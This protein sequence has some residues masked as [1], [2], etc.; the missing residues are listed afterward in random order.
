MSKKTFLI[1]LCLNFNAYGVDNI[2][3][4]ENTALFSAYYESL[5]IITSKYI[6]RDKNGKRSHGKFQTT[7]FLSENTY[8]KST[9]TGTFTNF[10]IELNGS[11]KVTD[12]QL[13]WTYIW[14]PKKAPSN[15]VSFGI[16]FN[17]QLDSP[18][19][20]S[21]A[22]TPELLPDNLGWRWVSPK[23]KHIEVNFSPALARITFEKDN[24]QKILA[25]FFSDMQKTLMTVKI[26]KDIA[27]KRPISLD[28]DNFSAHSWHKD[29]LPETTSPVD[30]SFLNLSDKPAGSHGY[31]VSRNESLFFEDGTPAK[32][33]G[34]NIM[35]RAIFKTSD[36]DIKRHARRIAQLGFNL[37]RIHHHDSSWVKPNIFKSPEHNTLELSETSLKKL[38]WWIKCLK[39]EGIYLWLDLHVG[40]NFTNNDGIVN[41]D[42]FAKGKK[43]I[44][45]KGFS[46][47]NK[48]IQTLMKA[49]N[50]AYLSHVNPLTQLAYKEDPAVIALLLTNENDLS[51]HFGNAL[52]PIKKVPLH[53][54][55]FDEDVRRF[56]KKHGLSYDK[57]WRTWEM[58]VSKI[59]LNDVEHRFNQQMLDHLKNLNIKS[60]VA[61]TNSWGKMGLYSL[62]SLTDGNIIDAHSYGRA[63][64]FDFNPRFNPG[65]LSWIGAA[66]VSGKPLSV[67]EWNIEPFPARDRFTAP[68]YTAGIA[69]LQGWDA[70][71]LYGYSHNSLSKS[72]KGNNYSSYN[73]PAI[74][75]M[76]PAAA[77]IYRQNHVTPAKKNYLLKLSRNDFFFK[78]QNP[79]SSKTIRTLLEISR[80]SIAIPEIPELLWLKNNI[81]PDGNQIVINDPDL[82]FIPAGQNFIESDTGEL[83]RDWIK[84]IH[85]INTDKSQ[86][87][88]GWIGGEK[89]KL[90]DV[91][92]NISTKKAVVAV[93]SLENKAIRES[94]KLLIT[95]MARSRPKKDNKLPFLSEPVSGEIFI[96]APKE[97]KLYPIKK[98]GQ[99]GSPLAF[100]Y[101]NKQYKITLS[102]NMQ[103]HW[104]IVQK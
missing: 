81:V 30:L 15:A 61:T 80:L 59:Y 36:F 25:L 34:T 55:V 95:V 92:F 27:L 9:F 32:F 85:T 4:D 68:V 46:Y 56:T 89:I 69:N 22:Q 16:E 74:M 14:D 54:A 82:D 11:V 13:D 19:F 102:E 86:V 29:I 38:D 67:T 101:L 88:S 20:T 57:T 39:D 10:D 8:A 65:F 75:G 73:D 33:W 84:G 28:Y 40:R 90:R 70:M 60:L 35:A 71:M 43:H 26:D 99:L 41:F 96:S 51:H 104:F 12:H 97:L 63:E 5:P 49:F 103:T 23:G 83:K 6:S 21:K 76:M 7:H 52:L 94:S 2:R 18:S 37:V 77:L 87:A 31:I 58:G 79:K 64:E 44:R 45:A 93:Q 98:T 66:Q 47:Y 78:Y 1:L 72:G 48:E 53:N 17:F 91:T 24:K 42:D 50:K 62:P 100:P 3:L